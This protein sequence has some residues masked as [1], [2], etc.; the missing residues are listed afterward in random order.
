MTSSGFCSDFM[1][2]AIRQAKKAFDISEAPVGAVVV[3]NNEIVG[4]GYNL[5]ETSKNSLH[6]AEIIAIHNA[7]CKLA[8]W[9]LVDCELY[10][11]LEPCLMCAGAMLQS[12]IRRL[13]FGAYDN[14]SGVCGSVID[15]FEKSV[16]NHTIEV[17]GGIMEEECGG[18][19]TDFFKGL[20]KK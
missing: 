6:H 7:C 11:T 20:R 1:K 8:S 3:R 10:C 15:V 9:R 4:T 13:Y 5:R 16:F 14:K 2:E 18:L 17:Y 19:L 12:R